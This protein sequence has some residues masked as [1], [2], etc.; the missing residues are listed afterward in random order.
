MAVT[1]TVDRDFPGYL[2]RLLY[3]ASLRERDFD[4]Y[5][6]RYFNGHFDLAGNFHPFD[7]GLR[8]GRRPMQTA[9]ASTK[10]AAR[11]IDFCP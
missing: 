1:T 10:M 6:L 9:R 11:M 2:N 5:S 8:R 4:L 3:D 7:D